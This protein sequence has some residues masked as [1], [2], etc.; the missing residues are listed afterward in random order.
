MNLVSPR[1]R[2]PGFRETGVAIGVIAVTLENDDC[3]TALPRRTC[4]L[5]K[6]RR[7]SDNRS[8]QRCS[9]RLLPLPL[10]ACPF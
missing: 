4:R 9:H 10:R 8:E 2:G 7:K 1:S 5:P 3:P 6:A